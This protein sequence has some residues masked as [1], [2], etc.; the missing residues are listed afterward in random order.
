MSH[1]SPQTPEPD[2][3][4]P[5]PIPQAPDG[6]VPPPSGTASQG[7]PGP[8]PHGP[9]GGVPQGYPPPTAYGPG[10]TPAGGFNPAPRSNRG[11]WIGGAIGL[12]VLLLCCGCIGGFGYFVYRITEDMEDDARGAVSD[13]LDDVKNERYSDAYDSLCDEARDDQ[14][15]AEFTQEMQARAKKFSDFD[16]TDS[17][18][19]GDGDYT[20]KVKLTFPD[21][22]TDREN[23]DVVIEGDND[24]RVCP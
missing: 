8:V 4:E 3:N 13:Y 24:L 1:P 5:P 21:N 23:Y 16:V 11:W 6:L 10:H 14:T 9:Y 18:V 17:S 20:I 12:L 2:P 15:E 22:S 19:G 7:P